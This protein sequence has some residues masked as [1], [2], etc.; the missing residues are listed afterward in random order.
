MFRRKHI[1]AL[2]EERVADLKEAHASEITQLLRLVEALA[3]QVE[4]LRAT[5]G[6]PFIQTKA[7]VPIPG[8]EVLPAFED[9]DSPL[10]LSEEEEDIRALADNGHMDAW[11]AEALREGLR[12]RGVDL[13]PL[14]T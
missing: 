1:D 13:P 3:E 7:P 10:H 5:T 9:E 4:Y 2:W 12:A 8:M 6:R 14:T 11:E